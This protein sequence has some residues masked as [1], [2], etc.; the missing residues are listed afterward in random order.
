MDRDFLSARLA[1]GRSIESI[2][3]EAG[4]SAS[5]V[6]YWMA[7]HGL[8]PSATARHAPK[9]ALRG[10][11][12]DELVARDLSIRQIAEATGRS[13]STVRYWLRQYGLETTTRARRAAA[14]AELEG[15]CPR[16]GATT[17][18]RTPTGTV[19]GRCRSDAVTEWR[20]R[21][22]RILIEE[23]GGRC[24]LC[25]YDR[26]VAALQFHHVDPAQK[27]FGLG[28]RGLARS[29]DK[30]R[31]EAKK[32]VLVCANCHAEVEAGLTELPCPPAERVSASVNRGE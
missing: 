20:R 12:L 11:Q 5:T 24:I 16:H 9:G 8:S 29:I 22:K 25:G 17:F 13:A 10:N 4:K 19:C 18:V 6:S 27:S 1:A 14:R 30:L 15:I 26:C 31:A 23:A 28:S 32:C 7:K 21:A 3:R 2:A